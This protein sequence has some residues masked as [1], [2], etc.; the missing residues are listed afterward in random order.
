VFPLPRRV[1]SGARNER[2][3]VVIFTRQSVVRRT[4]RVNWPRRCAVARGTGSVN[5]RTRS[6]ALSGPSPQGRRTLSRSVHSRYRKLVVSGDPQ[7][8]HRPD[9]QVRPVR[10]RI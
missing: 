10:L 5:G 3:S 4:P 1:L 8:G 6:F 7:D 2:E 9:H